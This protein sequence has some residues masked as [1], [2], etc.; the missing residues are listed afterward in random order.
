MRKTLTYY[1]WY[2]RL[3]LERD[4]AAYSYTISRKS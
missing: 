3:L 1:R 4:D 2:A